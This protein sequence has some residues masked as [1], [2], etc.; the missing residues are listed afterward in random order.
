MERQS[1][2]VATALLHALLDKQPNLIKPEPAGTRGGQS[3]AE[4]CFGF[5]QRYS[6]LLDQTQEKS[7]R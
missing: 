5:I 1:A 6:E 7:Q 2:E 3:V 4:F